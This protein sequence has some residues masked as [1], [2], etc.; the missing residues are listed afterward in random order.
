MWDTMVTQT[1]SAT[2]RRSSTAHGGKHEVMLN[3]TATM[4]GKFYA[5]FD[6]QLREL[7]DAWPSRLGGK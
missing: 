1:L 5:P 6:Q 3:A 7:I 2:D 4:L